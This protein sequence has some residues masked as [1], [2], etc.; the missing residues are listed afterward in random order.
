MSD[1]SPERQAS[2]TAIM[3]ATQRALHHKFADRPLILDDPI[4]ARLL[5]A[6][7]E[8]VDP[9]ATRAHT[10]VILRSRYCEDRLSAAAKRGVSQFVIL[11]AGFETFPYRQP[12]WAQDLHIYEVDHHASQEDK[13]T[14][15]AKAGVEIPPNLEYVAIDFERTTLREGLRQS[16]LDFTRPTFFS[17]LGVLVY[18]TQEAIDAIF[19]LV[20]EFPPGSEMVFT[21]PAGTAPE[22]SIA[23]VKGVGEPFHAYLD[24]DQLRN[25]LGV[26]GLTEFSI[27]SPEDADRIYFQHRSDGLVAAHWPA[28]A[29]VARRMP[30][31]VELAAR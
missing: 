23:I 14:R 27:L 12:A 16:T 21:F 22:D 24:P 10:A 25:D 19:Q 18:L 6:D 1:I 20:A 31:A 5:G 3:A 28:V 15:L 2:Q 13:R 29:T 11:G 30:A 9:N 26:L 4:A 8:G 7:F 17:C